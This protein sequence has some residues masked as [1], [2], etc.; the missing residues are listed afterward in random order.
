MF[1]SH[2]TGLLIASD[3]AARGRDFPTVEHVI[4]YQVIQYQVPMNTDVRKNM[5]EGEGMRGR[6]GEKRDKVVS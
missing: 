6:E 4:Q 5:G 3:V 1:N 2:A